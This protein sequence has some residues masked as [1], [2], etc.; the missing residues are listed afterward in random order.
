MGSKMARPAKKETRGGARPN[1]GPK[2][3]TLSVRQVQELLKRA[4]D[5]AKRTGKT[6]DDILLEFVYG[7]D[8]N[9]DPIQIGVRDRLAA[10]KLFKDHTSIK[11]GEGGEADKQLGPTIYLPEHDAPD[12]VTPIK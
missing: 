8:V 11:P 7:E 4:K 6:V 5:F 2:K 3:Q 12:N 9:G 1:S 10:L